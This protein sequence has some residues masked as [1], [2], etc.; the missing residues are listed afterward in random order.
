MFLFFIWLSSILGTVTAL[1][2]SHLAQRIVITLIIIIFV[3]LHYT[4]K[5]H[6]KQSYTCL[7]L[8]FGLYLSTLFIYQA[9]ISNIN[10]IS[11]NTTQKK[12]NVQVI[13]KKYLKTDSRIQVKELD[14]GNIF[15]LIPPRHHDVKDL[16]YGGVY[17]VTALATF[18]DPPRNPGSFD[19]PTYMLRKGLSGTLKASSISL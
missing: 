13:E 18:P 15:L 5:T 6:G 7:F 8:F 10:S 14:S 2:E 12:Y 4:Q 1:N 19:Y 9:R 11:S 17:L 3:T 16:D